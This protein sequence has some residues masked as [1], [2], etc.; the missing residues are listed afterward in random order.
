MPMKPTLLRCVGDIWA[1]DIVV[2]NEIIRKN[3]YLLILIEYLS[4]WAIT[5]VLLSFDSDH[6]ANVLLFKVILKYSTPSRLITDNGSN[7][8]FDVM[9][10]VCARLSIARSRTLVEYTQGDRLCERLNC[11]IKTSLAAYVHKEPTKWD[12]YL[13][14]ITLA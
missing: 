4:K 12:E 11:T 8:I 6:V 3:K 2:L 14:F 7:Y 13:P 5:V 10:A 9:N 1:L